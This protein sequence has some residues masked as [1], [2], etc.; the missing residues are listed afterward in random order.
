MKSLKFR[1]TLYGFVLQ[2]IMFDFV[3]EAFYRMST[4]KAKTFDQNIEINLRKTQK[5]RSLLII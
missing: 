1:K 3:R 2:L 4:F 5:V